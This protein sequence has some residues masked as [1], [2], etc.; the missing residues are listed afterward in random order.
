MIIKLLLQISLIFIIFV[1]IR[2]MG[3]ERKQK[4]SEINQFETNIEELDEGYQIQEGIRAPQIQKHDDLTRISGI[5][6]KISSILADAGIT[7]YTQLAGMEEN[8]MRSILEDANIRL[9]DPGSWIQQAK[10]LQ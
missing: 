1:F 2:L 5:G 3:K 4:K 8:K 10:E 6:P 9:A 7:T